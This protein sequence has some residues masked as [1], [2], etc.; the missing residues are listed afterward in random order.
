MGSESFVLVSQAIGTVAVD[1]ELFF[2]LVEKSSRR[3]VSIAQL[4]IASSHMSMEAKKYI[5]TVVAL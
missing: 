5:V 3:I 2:D 4:Y 1:F